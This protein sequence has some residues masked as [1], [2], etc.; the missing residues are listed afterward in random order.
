MAPD[1]ALQ[2]LVDKAEIRDLMMRYSRGL[3]RDDL[4]LV[5][6]T[7]TADAYANYPG[8]EG[9]GLDDI[10][11]G[12]RAS[13]SRSDRR[14][15]FMGDQDI[16]IRGD[17]A[18]VETYAIDYILYTVD[19]TQYQSTGGLRYQDRMVRQN[20]GWRVEHRVLH[21]DW[22]RNSLMDTGVP[23]REMVPLPD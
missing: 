5:S 11:S 18:D 1:P 2:E 23:G 7:F 17:T 14:T 20:G 22:R 10:I 9:H 16:Q 3:D 12:L 15:H 6:S 8:R 13:S 21:V 4:D 19:D